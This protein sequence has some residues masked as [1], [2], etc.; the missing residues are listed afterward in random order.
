MW[1]LGMIKTTHVCIYMHFV[2]I[3]IDAYIHVYVRVY[4]FTGGDTHI[5]RL[6]VSSE[7]TETKLS[8]SHLWH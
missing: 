1:L 8:F 4:T 2:C 6:L 5:P 3:T 7:F